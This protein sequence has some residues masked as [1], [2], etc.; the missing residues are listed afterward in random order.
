MSENYGPKARAFR[1][2][3]CGRL[4]VCSW[5]GD[6]TGMDYDYALG[7]ITH[8]AWPMNNVLNDCPGPVVELLEKVP[9]ED[10]D[11]LLRAREL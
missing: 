11:T 9:D 2:V 3:K 7:P 1:C 6:Y 8:S 4:M 10:T 5:G